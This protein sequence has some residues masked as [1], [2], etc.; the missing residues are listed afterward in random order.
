M[1][2][3]DTN[4]FRL[5]V[6]EP[7]ATLRDTFL[8]SVAQVPDCPA[9]LLEEQSWSYAEL[10]AMARR[11]AGLLLK[12][13]GGMPARVG[14]LADRGLTAY[15]GILASLYAGAAFVPLNRKFPAVRT[16]TMLEQA[17]VDVVIVEAEAL[18][19]ACEV[20][21]GC[22]R[23]VPL[24]VPDGEERS[25]SEA[26]MFGPEAL[27]SAAPLVTLPTATPE[28]GAYLLFTSGSS[29]QPK[30][31]P[32]THANV[33]AFLGVNRER[34]GLTPADRVSQTFDLTF[35]LSVFDLFMAWGAGACVVPLKSIELLAPAEF[36][37]KR[38]ITVWFSVPS[39]AALCQRQKL[40]EPGS[41]PS[42]RWSL[43]C[44]EALPV[45]SAEAWQEAAPHSVVENLYGPTEL[46]IACAAYRWEP[47]RSPAECVQGLVPIGQ[48]Y[49]GLTGRVVDEAL[50]EVE[51]GVAG[52][53]CVA[54]PQTFTGY[55]RAPQLTQE[56][57]FERVG[58]DGR[59]LRFYRTGDLVKRMPGGALVYL[60]RGDH[61]IKVGGYRVELGEV[62]A[63]MRRAGCVDAVAL[64]WP[65]VAHP[66]AILGVATGLVEPKRVLEAIRQ[67]LPVYMVPRVITV[68]EDPP[69]NANGKIH[70]GALQERIH[71]LWNQGRRA[72]VRGA[73]ALSSLPSRIEP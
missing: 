55:W 44:G 39:V 70:R 47:A 17:D 60:G 19:Q 32:I 9:L 68:I 52:E 64:P 48:L 33:L 11:W 2:M 72:D 24:L 58:A 29:G 20:V 43:F 22:T 18:P 61:Q 23:P 14:V 35:D 57:T 45:T 31:V 4:A 5:P 40:L 21:A 50:V 56:R 28:G 54:G 36:I 66:E 73:R 25:L 30:G 7:P 46:T 37:R 62:E 67:R 10:D 63:A 26:V 53:L 38:G 71:E 42:L 12:A 65:S 51:E 13:S 49:E 34:Y 41:M 27:A 8:W 16:R 6:I 69:L 59:L 3:R 15:V 1:S